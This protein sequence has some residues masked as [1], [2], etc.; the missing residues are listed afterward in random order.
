MVTSHPWLPNVCN[1][2]SHRNNLT[3]YDETLKRAHDSQIVRAEE[4]IK[5]ILSQN[6][7]VQSQVHVYTLILNFK[8]VSSF[9]A[10][11]IFK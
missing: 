3:H 8:A 10:D 7:L 11:G 9:E 6:D 2:S 1:V 5:S 4:N